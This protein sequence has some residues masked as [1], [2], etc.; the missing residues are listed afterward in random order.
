MLKVPSFT[1]D[2]V[3]LCCVLCCSVFCSVM[4]YAVVIGRI[5][6]P[7]GARRAVLY[8]TESAD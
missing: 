8:N 7:R 4:F 1:E 3:L 6:I 5:Y 2:F